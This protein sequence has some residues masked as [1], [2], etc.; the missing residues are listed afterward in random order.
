M[1]RW[2]L[3]TLFAIVSW[4]LWGVLSKL[5]GDKLSPELLQALMTLGILPV[6]VAAALLGKSEADP[7][8]RKLGKA[9]AFGAGVLSC[10]ANIAYYH[11]LT[12]GGK[13]AV[14]IPL[15][16]LYPVVTVVLSIVLLGERINAVQAAGV[17]LSLAAIWLFNVPADTASAGESIASPWLV[18]ALVPIALWGVTGFLQ[19]VSTNHVSGDASTFWFHAAFVPVAVVILVGLTILSVKNKPLPESIT[20]STWL[21]VFLIGLT[22]AAGNYGLLA[23]FARG[24]KA[25][26]ITPV[27][28]LYPLIT[29]SAAV[30]FLGEK[31]SAREIAGIGTALASVL[32]ISWERRASSGAPQLQAS[33]GSSI[34]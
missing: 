20:G 9:Y 22:F 8:R 33:K 21:L 25:T 34:S 27:S 14:V 23:A 18:Y 15:T 5:I 3:W 29:I 2:L 28:A 17:G 13:A 10:V 31:I 16:G 12:V 7:G 24:G 30:L 11:A 4:G 19:K 26:I 6:M 32:A 1:P